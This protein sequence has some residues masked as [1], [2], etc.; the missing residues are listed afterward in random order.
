VATISGDL[1][2]VNRDTSIMIIEELGYPALLQRCKDMGFKVFESQDY[3]LNIIGIRNAEGT[4]NAFDDEMH[5]LY[6]KDGSWHHHC[7]KCTTDA[8]LH[9]LLNPFSRGTA[10]V[11]HD[12][13]Y[14]GVY[15][16]GTH[17]GYKALS[18]QGNSI[19]VW[20]DRNKD[21]KHDYTGEIDEGYFGINI[22]RANKY[23]ESSLVNNWSAGC[24][25]IAD[26]RDFD[27]FISLC[28]MQIER[29]GS[30]S[31]SYTLLFGF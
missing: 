4:V 17:T 31:F 24:Q 19:A 20:R 11:V 18:Q 21:N 27:E 15:K 29:V 3:D 25:V 28:E 13:Q 1:H 30:N 26:P 22:H 5:V 14:R 2:L 10:I 16:L 12:R 9:Y 6:L 7:Y 8:G 23:K